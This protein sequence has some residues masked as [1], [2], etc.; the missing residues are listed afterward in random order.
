MQKIRNFFNSTY[1][2]ILIYLV[3]LI[4][5][6]FKQQEA[7]IIFYVV[8]AVIIILLNCNR[9]NIVTLI[10]AG[11]INYRETSYE[12][13]VWVFVF[14]AVAILPLLIYDLLK[15]KIEYK[16]GI[17]IAMLIILLS[18]IL[19]LINIKKEDINYG[20]VGVSQYVAFCLIYFYFMNKREE[21]NHYYIS[22]NAAIMSLAISLQIIYTLTKFEGDILS[23]EIDL[24]WG[25]TNSIAITYLLLIPLTFYLYIDNQKK[26]QYLL[27]NI[28]SISMLVLTFCKGA[29]LT[30]LVLIL[31][32]LY[33]AYRR[34]QN[35]KL[36]II[37]LFLSLLLLASILYMFYNV[38]H[39]REGFVRYF[40]QMGERGWFNDNSRIDIFK[41]GADVFKK[42]PLFGA[43]SYTAKPYLI[44]NGYHPNLKH[45]HNYII[46]TL[47][48]LGL[49][50]LVSFGN[51]IYQII[52]KSLTPNFYNVSVLFTV[53]AMLLH[54]LVDN[55][56]YNPI[57]PLIITIYLTNLVEY[58]KIEELVSC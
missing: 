9:I 4:C 41:Y 10:M 8:M 17:F 14:A 57:V 37:S 18:N 24:D 58:R 7:A 1:F 50:G 54:G 38:D 26:F 21:N 44:L 12:G 48:T 30:I 2:I 25:S 6:Y 47:A 49:V 42:F 27:I 3:T 23:K 20:L 36:Y 40:N 51:Y 39:V 11:V 56:W 28:L 46:Q 5:W 22:K 13:N 29:Y 16:N 19:S 33:L 34:V 31:P 45:Y 55:T 43:G 32:F 15:H 35:K 52:K 53:F